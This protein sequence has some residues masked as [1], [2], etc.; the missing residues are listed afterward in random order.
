[1]IWANNMLDYCQCNLAK[2]G[3]PLGT[4]FFCITLYLFYRFINLLVA[5]VGDFLIPFLGFGRSLNVELQI[6]N[7]D[8]T[9]YRILSQLMYEV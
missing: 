9:D 1:M 7:M 6:E 8:V 4:P 3:V 5:L 2:K